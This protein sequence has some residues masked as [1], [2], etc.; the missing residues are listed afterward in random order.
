ME[1]VRSRIIRP[2]ESLVFYSSFNTLWV[3]VYLVW[4]GGART[5]GGVDGIHVD[6]WH[7]FE[8]N[9]GSEKSFE[10]NSTNSIQYLLLCNF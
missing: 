5:C 10:E 7:L 3:L 8:Q 9:L 2:Q 6:N 1:W 4:S